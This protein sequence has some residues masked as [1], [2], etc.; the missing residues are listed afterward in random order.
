MKTTQ[1]GAATSVFATTAVELEG[2]SGAYLADCKARGEGL[3]WA[4]L[5][6]AGLGWVAGEDLG[7]AGGQ[8]PLPARAW[9]GSGPP[10]PTL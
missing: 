7:R 3:G 4:G 9:V 8:A 6:W 5:G 1:Q 10:R 2:Q